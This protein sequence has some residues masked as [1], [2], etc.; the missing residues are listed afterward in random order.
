M[1]NRSTIDVSGQWHG[2]MK[3]AFD[4]GYGHRLIVDA[5]DS[6]GG[7][8]EGFMPAYLLLAS[9]AACTGIDIANILRKQ[10]Q[11][12]TSLGIEVSGVQEPVAPWA[13]KEIRLEYKLQ[14]RK[15]DDRAVQRAIQLAEDKY[16]S[17]GATIGDVAAISSSHS[18]SLQA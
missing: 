15:L 10:R 9:L 8:F 18:V 5:P 17:I 2:G 7:P 16:C 13:F 14:G 4:D 3:F 1:A 6:D 12:L 11:E